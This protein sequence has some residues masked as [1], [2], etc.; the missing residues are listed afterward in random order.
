MSIKFKKV[1]CQTRSNKKIFGICD[2]PSPANDPAYIDETDGSKWI[3]VI[4]ND[5]RLSTVFTA[6]D[7]CI[8]IK[9]AEGKM[10]KRCDGMLM[11]NSTVIFVELKQRGA[12]G[13]AWVLDAE[14]Q[15]MNSIKHFEQTEISESFKQKKAY[16]SNSEHPKFKTSQIGRMER[17]YSKTGY[18]LRIEARIKLE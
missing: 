17:F 10:E 9:D 6:I 8:E 7:N 1:Q 14:P 5:N 4:E 16:I 3:A 11:Y 2:N 15:L 12:K 13:N 18:I